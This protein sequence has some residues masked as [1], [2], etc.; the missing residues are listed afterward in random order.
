MVRTAQGQTSK[1][2]RLT[3]SK[4]VESECCLIWYHVECG[5]IS[6]DEYQGKSE[7]VWFCRK[8][9]AIRDKNKSVQQAKSVLRYV[10]N[11]VRTVK[12]D[13]EKVL[14]TSSKFAV[15]NRDTKHKQEIG[16]FGFTI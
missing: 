5:D 7:T 12:G 6:D 15:H 3:Q 2:D 13:P 9:I 1:Y 10:D 8:C 16:I 14:L 11:I 4:G